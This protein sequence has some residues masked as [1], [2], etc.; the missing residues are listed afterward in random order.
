V[1]EEARLEE[2]GP[3][4]APATEGWFV[5]NVG[6]AVWET[7]DAFGSACFFERA[8]APFAEIGVSLRVLW[9]G[10]SKLLYHSE[11]SQEDFLVLAGECLLLI[12]GEERPLRARDFVHRP[13]MNAHAFVATGEGP[14]VVLMTG[15][16]GPEWPEGIVYPRADVALRHQAGVETETTSVPDALSAYPKWKP[17]RPEGWDRLPWS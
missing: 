7:N 3:G 16:R 6:D 4:L 5:V 1:V 8:D 13:P 2:S 14:C 11:P 9:P 10:R 15:S 17:E 12:E